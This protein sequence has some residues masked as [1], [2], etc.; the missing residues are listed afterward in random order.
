[1]S[2]GGDLEHVLYIFLCYFFGGET[3]WFLN[4]WECQNRVWL[5]FDA[6]LRPE[7]LRG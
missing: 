6:C 5:G 2:E 1:M 3:C 7:F 4:F